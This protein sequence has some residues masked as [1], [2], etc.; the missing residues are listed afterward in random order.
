MRKSKLPPQLGAVGR[1]SCFVWLPIILSLAACAAGPVEDFDDGLDASVASVASVEQALLRSTNPPG[2]LSVSQ[3]PQFVSV[4]F[5]DN[6]A[7]EG[8]DWT[9]DTFA[10]LKNPAGSGNAATFDGTPVRSTFYHN[11]LYLSGMQSSWQRAVSAGHETADHTTN[12]RDG[13]SFSTD[14]WIGEIDACRTQLM[15]AFGLTAQQVSG[16]RAPFLKY[17]DNLY[18]VLA[19]R[20]PAFAYDTSIPSCLAAGEDGSNCAWPYTLD[21]GSQDAANRH[22]LN[23]DYPNVLAHAGFWEMPNPVVIVPANLRAGIV[24]SQFIGGSSTGKILGMDISMFFDAKMNKEQ[25]LAAL[26]NTLDLHLAGNRAPLI[27]VAHTHVYASSWDG[28]V[29]QISLAERRAVISEFLSYALSKS[30]VRI[31]PVADILKWMKNPVALGNCTGSCSGKGCGDDGCGHSCG[32]CSGNASCGSDNQ[33]HACVPVCDGKSCGSDGCGGSCGTCTSGLSCN[34]SGQC[35]TGPCGAAEWSASKTYVAGDLVTATCNS[36]EAGTACFNKGGKVLAFR[37]DNPAWCS[38]RPGGGQAGW[39]SAWSAQAECSG[40]PTCT[41]SCSG[42]VCGDNGCGGS[43]GTCAGGTACNASGQC[44][45]TCTPSCSGKVCGDNGCGGSCGTCASGTA[46]NAS[47]QCQSTC[48]PSCSGKVCGDNGCGG[49]CGTCASGKSCDSSGQCVVSGSGCNAPAWASGV[50]YASGAVVSAKCAVST[51]GTA[52]YQKVGQSFTFRC[53][54][55]GWCSLSPGSDQAGWW[56]AW[57]MLS[58]CP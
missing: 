4:T 37:C 27:F 24:E 28:N 25:S 58:A 49:S 57:T 38:L 52:C 13:L 30:V 6:F 53:D 29:P 42:K 55:P 20:T 34:A 39:W 44:Q 47:G 5:D 21:S 51:V 31:R 11:C 7:A 3:V 18:T 46:C 36:T 45:S 54:N 22:A 40:V 1:A 32:T 17:N 8:M 43:C 50:S 19:S 23:P 10:N 2:G 33:C 41:P 12:H 9:V 35:T 56:S 16:F 15:S 14:D 48:T 26:K